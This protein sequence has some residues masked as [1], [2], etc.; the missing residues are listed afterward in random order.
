VAARGAKPASRAATRTGR[1]TASA[2]VPQ[3]AARA[4]AERKRSAAAE[5]VAS[6]GV[7]HAPEADEL[8]RDELPTADAEE[9]EDLD[10]LDEDEDPRSQI[11]EDEDDDWNGQHEDE[12]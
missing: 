10:W 1:K 12:W 11:V 5:G 3:L 4:T 2:R 6:L 9:D 7:E 8:H